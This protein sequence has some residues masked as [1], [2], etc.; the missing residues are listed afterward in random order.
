M[1]SLAKPPCAKDVPENNLKI[2]NISSTVT[3]QTC[4]TK[5]MLNQ[6]S[7]LEKSSPKVKLILFDKS[8]HVLCPQVEGG[9]GRPG[10]S[11]R[12]RR[13]LGRGLLGGRV[14]S[15]ERGIQWVQGWVH[16]PPPPLAVPPNFL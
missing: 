2:I 11:W 8:S 12:A 15:I 14:F 16:A 7:T 6:V 5:Y 4:Q 3:V 1:Q 9:L 13:V 10:G